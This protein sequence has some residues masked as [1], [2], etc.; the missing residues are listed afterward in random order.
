[1]LNTNFI[2][3]LL[4]FIFFPFLQQEREKKEWVRIL[5]RNK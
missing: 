2:P 1:M 5:M 4:N 3:T